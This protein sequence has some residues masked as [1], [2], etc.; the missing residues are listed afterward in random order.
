MGSPPHTRG[1]Q[2]GG[3]HQPKP[4]GITPAHAGN[5]CYGIII[6]AHRRDHP[7]TRGE[8]RSRF[9]SR[10]R[11]RGSPPHT[12]GILKDSQRSYTPMGITPAHAGNTQRNLLLQAARWDYPRTRGEYVQT[13]VLGADNKG[14]PPH[15]RGIH[16]VEK[17]RPVSLGITPA[18]AGNTQWNIHEDRENRDHPRTRGEYF[19][20]SLRTSD[21]SGS[22]P[23][24]RGI[25]GMPGRSRSYPGITPAHAG[26]TRHCTW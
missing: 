10:S 7:R 19:R 22:P 17:S 8:Y 9:R 15:T 6:C 26:N 21:V 24:T 1:I 12:R 2:L 11:S 18:H 20:F 5:T 13:M 16:F 23:H 25:P 3:V 4:G 14:S